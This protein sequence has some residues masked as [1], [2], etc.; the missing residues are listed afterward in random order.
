MISCTQVFTYSCISPYHHQATV[1]TD[2]VKIL[3]DITYWCISLYHH[4]QATV[5][6]DRVKNVEDIAKST[7]HDAMNHI[8]KRALMDSAISEARRAQQDGGGGASTSISRHTPLE[9]ADKLTKC[10]EILRM[11][12]WWLAGWLAGRLAGCTGIFVGILGS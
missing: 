3:E 9:R 12:G 11:V 2:R 1:E 6:T 7:G 5:E 8:L 4:H 10:G